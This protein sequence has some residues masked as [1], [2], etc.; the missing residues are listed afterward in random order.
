MPVRNDV[1]SNL[2]TKL[3]EI[4]IQN[5]YHTEIKLVSRDVKGW[6]QCN[7]YELPALFIADDGTDEK[8]GYYKQNGT[9]YTL[10]KMQITLVGY[11]RATKNISVVFNKLFADLQKH[12]ESVNLGNNVRE[13][14][15]ADAMMTFT[16]PPHL[17]FQMP[18]TIL[19][20]FDK[21]NP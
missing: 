4:K 11:V 1:L 12:I 16:V 18:I 7:T 14:I 5:G 20:F 13:V 17:I 2:E 3:R 6:E 15:G 9:I 8:L 21:S 10:R 19:Y